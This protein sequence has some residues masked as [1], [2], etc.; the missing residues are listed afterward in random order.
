MNNRV[1]LVL[2]VVAV[3]HLENCAAIEPESRGSAERE[4]SSHTLRIPVQ[5]APDQLPVAALANPT[6]ES[7][8]RFLD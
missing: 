3:H 6:Q 7:S 8:D 5:L 1:V 4:H 2:N